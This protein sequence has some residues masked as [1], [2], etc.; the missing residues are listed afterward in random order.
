M[1]LHLDSML[2]E[3]T[4]TKFPKELLNEDNFDR[5]EVRRAHVSR[6]SRANVSQAEPKPARVLLELSVT[7]VHRR[8]LPEEPRL[9]RLQHSQR[10]QRRLLFASKQ[11]EQLYVLSS[12]HSCRPPKV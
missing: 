9:R 4:W 2:T 12:R 5:L 6:R 7:Q 11:P 8:E 1:G 10:S 3:H